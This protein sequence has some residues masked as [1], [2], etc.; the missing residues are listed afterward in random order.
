[1]IVDKKDDFFIRVIKTQKEEV[2]QYQGERRIAVTNI[3]RRTYSL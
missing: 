2:M 1:M 3:K